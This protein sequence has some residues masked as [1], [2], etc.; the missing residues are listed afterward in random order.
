MHRHSAHFM[1]RPS[2]RDESGKTSHQ[3]QKVSPKSEVKEGR[4]SFNLASE[5]LFSL[6]STDNARRVAYRTA[7]GEL[8]FLPL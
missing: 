1:K 4:W 6:G 2:H 8:R 7:T 5:S 3:G